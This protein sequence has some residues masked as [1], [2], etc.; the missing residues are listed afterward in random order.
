MQH[1]IYMLLRLYYVYFVSE[2]AYQEA[3]YCLESILLANPKQENMNTVY[4]GIG[5]FIASQMAT[6][7][8]ISHITY[9]F[10]I[11]Q[12]YCKVLNKRH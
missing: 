1:I 4:L 11:V 2:S 6:E 8:N 9:F 3:A 7:N 5:L 12:S 10:G